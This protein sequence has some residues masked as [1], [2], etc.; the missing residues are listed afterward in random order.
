MVNSRI[1]ANQASGSEGSTGIVQVGTVGGAASLMQCELTGNNVRTTDTWRATDC[2]IFSSYVDGDFSMK[3][4]NVSSNGISGVQR[5]GAAVFA[6]AN[7]TAVIT[8]NLFANNSIDTSRAGGSNVG[9]IYGTGSS[10]TVENNTLYRNWLSGSWGS[11][12]IVRLASS[13]VVPSIKNAILTNNIFYSPVKLIDPASAAVSH[14]NR[15]DGPLGP[16]PEG[17][18]NQNPLFAGPASGDFHLQAGSPCVNT[19]DPAAAYNDPDST[20]NDMGAYGGPGSASGVGV[21][22]PIGPQL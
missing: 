1:S 4:S 15:Q 11:S 20:P 2:A 17:N 10:C 22:G 21:Q 19:G 16:T 3:N 12:A 9:V 13:G 7:G 18:I 14:S 5:T 6:Y 8:N